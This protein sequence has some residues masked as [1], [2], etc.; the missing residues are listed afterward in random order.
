MCNSSDPRIKI[1][2]GKSFYNKL[3][4]F[5]AYRLWHDEKFSKVSYLSLDIFHMCMPENRL[6]Q[7]IQELK[8]NENNS[9]NLTSD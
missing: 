2:M 3:E 1:F 7:K 5:F 9:F 4:R 8:L 6:N